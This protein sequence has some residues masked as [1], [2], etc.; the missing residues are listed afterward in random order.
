MNKNKLQ[1]QERRGENTHIYAHKIESFPPGEGVAA[2]T[3]SGS[4]EPLPMPRAMILHS[5]SLQGI[6]VLTCPPAHIA[7]NH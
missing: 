4:P 7:G 3:T 5:Y 6:L 1:Q 2:V